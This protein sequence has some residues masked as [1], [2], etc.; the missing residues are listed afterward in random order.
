MFVEIGLCVNKAF[1]GQTAFQD[2]SLV[3]DLGIDVLFG[4]R[5]VIRVW[6]YC[7]NLI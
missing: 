3:T 1:I 5:C 2:N 4:Y 7:F 6:F